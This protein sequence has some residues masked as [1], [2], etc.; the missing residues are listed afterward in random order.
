[1]RAAIILTTAIIAQASQSGNTVTL[2][3]GVDMPILAF[4]AQVWDSATCESATTSALEA[5]FR[6]VWS[7][8]LIGA[9]CQKAQ[10]QA[11]NASTIPLHEIFLAGTVNSGSCS[12]P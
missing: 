10:W 9:D 11:I 5:G 12:G 6:N 4:A 2:N 7:S 8:M 1:M 3:N